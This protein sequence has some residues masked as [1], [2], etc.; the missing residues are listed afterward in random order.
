MIMS[1]FL[2]KTWIIVSSSRI[3]TSTDNSSATILSKSNSSP[4]NSFPDYSTPNNSFLGNSSSLN[5]FSRRGILFIPKPGHSDPSVW[6]LFSWKRW[7]DCWIFIL[8]G[9]PLKDYPFN[10]MQA[11]YL[12]GKST[13]TALHDLAYKIDGSLAQKKF[14]LM[15]REL[16]TTHLLNR[17]MTWRASINRWIDFMLRLRSVFV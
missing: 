11:A 15:S 12:K 16:L 4:D 9:G 8:R 14:A 1:Y 3:N 17:W 6:H 5:S 13:E 7:K 2:C 10:P